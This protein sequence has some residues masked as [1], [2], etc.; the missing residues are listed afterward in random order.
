MLLFST[1]ILLIMIEVA[2]LIGSLTWVASVSG[3]NAGNPFPIYAPYAQRFQLPNLVPAIDTTREA[4]TPFVLIVLSTIVLYFWPT[5]QTLGRRI[6]TQMTALA[7]AVIA[8]SLAMDDSPMQ[9]LT[10]DLREF[11]KPVTIIGGVFLIFQAE[12]QAITLLNNVYRLETPAERLVVWAMRLPIPLIL[13]GA[14]AL[15]SRYAPLA[16]ACA[17]ALVITFVTQLG[18]R[19]ASNYEKLTDVFLREGSAMATVGAILV[20]AL[21]SVLFGCRLAGI[22]PKAIVVS[23]KGVSFVSPSTFLPPSPQAAPDKTKPGAKGEVKEEP[24][25]DI[26]WSDKKKP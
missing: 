23:G 6:T 12:S 16:I 15:Y 22:R 1:C 13:I 26:K 11:W 20:I 10:G 4:I 18:R 14:H 5:N 21:A 9:W 8:M 3:W 7:F 17:V 2:A 25:I 19:P 24:V